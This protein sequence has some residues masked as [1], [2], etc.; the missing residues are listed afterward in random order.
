M[1]PLTLQSRFTLP[2]ET[3]RPHTVA[4][5]RSHG[6][7]YALDKGIDIGGVLVSIFAAWLL[8][9]NHRSR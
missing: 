1:T 6:L 3:P 8:E 4:D 2:A 7:D 5:W 9:G